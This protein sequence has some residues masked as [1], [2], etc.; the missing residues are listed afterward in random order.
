MHLPAEVL[1]VL[2]HAALL[3]AQ[4]HHRADVFLRHQDR[5]RDD[6]LADLLDLATDRAAST[7]SR[8]RRTRAVAH[9][10]LV[11]DRRRRRDQVHVVLALEP[12]LHDVHVQQAEEA[13]AEAEAQ[14]LR[15]LGLVVQRRVVELQL[16]ERVAQRLVLVRLD[17]IEAREHLRLHFLEAGQRARAPAASTQRDRVADLAPPSSSLMPA[18]M[19]P[20]SPADSCSRAA[21]LRREHADLLAVVGRARGHQQDLVARLQ[22]PVHHAHQH[23]D[24]DVVVEPRIDDQRLQRRIADRPSA[25]ACGR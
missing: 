8:S 21:E 16:V 5:R 14:R 25:A 18:M 22:R 6:R 12:L 23:D 9:Q 7:D 4:R 20:T 1:H 13:A 24:A 3:G 15:H 19:K 10:H 11:D 17:R 2:L